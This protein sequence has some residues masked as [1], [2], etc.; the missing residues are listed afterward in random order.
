MNMR[1]NHFYISILL[2][3]TVSLFCY[4]AA[5]GP[6]GKKSL[7]LISTSQEVSLGEEF[8]QEVNSTNPISDD[9]ILVAYVNHVGQKIAQL[10]DRAD[11]T[12]H[13]AVIDT[14]IVNAFACPGGYIYIYTG[15]LKA[16]ENEAQLAG[17]LAHEVSHV[18]AR[19][20]VK[21]LQQ[22]LGLQVLLSIALGESSELTQEAVGI[23]LAVL[24][25]AHSR[26]NEFEADEYGAI[27]MQKA[28]YN[29]E[30]MI[31]L[32]QKLLEMSNGQA[33][34]FE[35]I[36]ATHPPTQNRINRVKSQIQ[37]F[38]PSVRNLPLNQEEYQ[39]IKKRIG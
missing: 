6:G 14:P 36:M 7:I 27:Y 2:I 20:G 33:G 37:G 10:S 16:M 19:H 30:G 35:K 11:I 26:E 39:K 4:C 38:D 1:R 23:G 34:F 21:R 22:I 32:L 5:T 24:L 3:L 15:L 12:Y 17:V 25:Q 28:G 13:F 9:S 8:A 18:V 29:P 31:Q